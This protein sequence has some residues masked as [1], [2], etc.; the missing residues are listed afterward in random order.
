MRLQARRA[1]G[2]GIDFGAVAGSIILALEIVHAPGS[3]GLALPLAK[4]MGITG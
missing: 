2:A 1:S 4:L 3:A